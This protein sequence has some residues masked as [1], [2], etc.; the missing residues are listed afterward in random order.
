MEVSGNAGSGLA[1]ISRIRADSKFSL[2]MLDLIWPITPSYRHL[3]K[4]KGK[5]NKGESEAQIHLGK[6]K[7]GLLLT[8]RNYAAGFWTVLDGGMLE[9]N[10]GPWRA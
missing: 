8:F 10:L 1:R 4:M 2:C 5:Y 7:Q 3:E 9:T 6:M